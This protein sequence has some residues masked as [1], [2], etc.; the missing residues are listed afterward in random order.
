[1]TATAQLRRARTPRCTPARENTNRREISPKNVT[2]SPWS[3]ELLSAILGE[4]SSPCIAG[5]KQPV[6]PSP[7]SKTR[8]A[9]V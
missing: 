1:M 9:K 2:Y 3:F 6:R 8:F 7:F 5:E 4:I